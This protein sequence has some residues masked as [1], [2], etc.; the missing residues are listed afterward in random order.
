MTSDPR[1]TQTLTPDDW[2]LVKELV[3]TCHSMDREA[4]GPWLD[5]HCPPGRVRH[6]VERLLAGADSSP[7][8]MARSAPQ[9]ILPT[10][11]LIPARIGRFRIEHELGT[12]G[13]G[14]VYAAVDE[15]LGRPVAL[16]VLQPDAV[17]DEDQRKR[18][19]WDARAA[20]TLNHPNIVCVYETGEADGVDY[21]AMELV[22]GRTLADVLRT[23]PLPQSRAL[24]I[25]TQVAAALEAA[26]AHGIVHRDLKPSNVM[27][28]AAGIAKLVDFGL[29]KNCGGLPADN[30]A[31]TTVEGRLAG[32][33]VYMSPE[34]AEGADVDFR[35]DVFSFGSVL[36]EM[37]TRQR[38]FAGASTVSILA[39]IIHTEP[40]PPRAVL[41]TLD[42]RLEDIINRCLR[43]DRERRFQS[44]GEVRVRLQEVIDEPVAR[45]AGQSG[46]RFRSWKVAAVAAAA[47]AGGTFALV[48]VLRPA[49]PP[50]TAVSLSRLTWDGGLTTS[51]AISRDGTLLAYASDRGGRGD[52]DV[53]IQRM[54]GS[55][56]I[57]LTSDAADE[58]APAISPD[59]TK[60][61]YRSERG[62]GGVYLVPSLG[63][64]ERLLA[65][66]CR[67]PKYSPDGLWLACWTGDVGGAFYPNAA[68]IWLVSSSG[69]PL[70]QFRPDFQSAA[71]PLWTPDGSILFLGRKVGPAGTPVIDWWT[72][73]ENGGEL[74]SGAL[75]AFR[76]GGLTPPAG[77]FWIR[78]EAW[79]E[80]GSTVLFSARREDAI[81]VWAADMSPR[82]EIVGPPR[83]ATL[84]AAVHALPTAPAGGTSPSVVFA[85]LS[86]EFQLRRVTLAA[87]TPHAPPARLLPSV[88]QI[89][90]PSVS[91]DGRVL[92]FSTRQPN[93][94]RV[95]SVD[96]ATADQHLVTTVESSDFLRVVISGDGKTV[97]YGASNH[98]GT[99]MTLD[100]GV[101]E[102]ICAKCGWPTHVSFDGSQALF[103]S[104]GEEERLLLWSGGVLRP[105]ISRAEAKNRMQF[106][107]RFSPDL[108]W[109]ALCAG[110][111][112]IAKREI[113]VVPNAPERALSD[114]EWIPISEGQ[115]SDREPFWSP[116]GR[117]LFFISERDGFRCIWA[118]PMDPRRGVPTGPAVAVAHFH[119]ARELLRS[120]VPSTG[121][122]G[123]TAT[124]D[125]LIF[126]IAE[127]AG[128]L[129]WQ[130][131]ATR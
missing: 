114:E 5:V 67:D 130:R 57:R 64:T 104:A 19:L 17:V 80:S 12:G 45:A 25:A 112:D 13:M 59:G 76:D 62:G 110:T 2:E 85:S 72:A 131:G 120:P 18:L 124:A 35:S 51:P 41:P 8:F 87:G 102:T 39:R 23:E 90:S 47:A 40:P 121:G 15:R 38:A 123:L 92:V 43:K 126:T 86:V 61:A 99:R 97:V 113:V 100:R 50:A 105:L 98:A 49:E 60:V 56:P 108:R 11:R 16:K 63:G 69:G 91:A 83:H 88:S 71:F 115:T 89:G 77:S 129:W 109:V 10:A 6:E 73:G 93:G 95:M 81:N 118:R 3:F 53:W 96:M 82:G 75:R 111:R 128:N 74:A 48:S 101:P 31:P 65:P 30:S 46:R 127:S 125:G 21:V 36:Y 28:T 119:H 79:L 78:P 54:G 107:G 55:D 27:I 58:S 66:G 33:V 122:I 70:R 20:S 103:E 106:G 34:Q 84:G 9:Q 68:R 4:L 44:M 32:T 26:H 7:S 42:P 94:Y 22:P 29:A 117:R 116:D 37:L 1:A 24:S 52:L 14:V